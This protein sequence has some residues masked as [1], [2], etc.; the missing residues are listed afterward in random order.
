V[1]RAVDKGVAAKLRRET[2]SGYDI[3]PG[4]VRLAAMNLY[5]HGIGKDKSPMVNTTAVVVNIGASSSGRT[6][7]PP[8]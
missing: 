2:F 1:A 8:P 6:Q 3:V 7:P 4:V 5:L